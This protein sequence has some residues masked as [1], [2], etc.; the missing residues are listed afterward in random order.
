MTLN[1]DDDDDYTWQPDIEWHQDLTSMST[2][3]TRPNS[4]NGVLSSDVSLAC[5]KEEEKQLNPFN[6]YY[7]TSVEST[8]TIPADWL[9]HLPTGRCNQDRFLALH[10]HPA[11]CPASAAPPSDRRRWRCSQP[12]RLMTSVMMAVLVVVLVCCSPRERGVCWDL[13]SSGIFGGWPRGWSDLWTGR[14]PISRRR[15]GWSR[16]GITIIC[17]ADNTLGSWDIKMQGYWIWHLTNCHNWIWYK[18]DDDIKCSRT[19]VVKIKGI[20]YNPSLIVI[21]DS[22]G[23]S[24]HKKGRI[25]AI[26][27]LMFFCMHAHVV[28]VT[29]VSWSLHIRMMIGLPLV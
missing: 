5:I 19:N 7:S 28:S 17:T 23:W 26:V 16:S 11:H 6:W 18:K 12:S 1:D 20:A 25:V 27:V 22:L 9:R 2:Q 10:L 29:I 24:W 3:S 8:T 4:P 14:I 15:T 13:C 21:I